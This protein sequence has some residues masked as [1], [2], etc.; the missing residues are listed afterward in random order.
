MRMSRSSNSLVNGTAFA[1]INGLVVNISSRVAYPIRCPTTTRRCSCF[2]DLAND[3]R[4]R[5][6]LDYSGS[7]QRYAHNTDRATKDLLAMRPKIRQGD[8][9]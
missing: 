6:K 1:V 7:V 8:D 4:G 9:S 2:V 5:S 3:N